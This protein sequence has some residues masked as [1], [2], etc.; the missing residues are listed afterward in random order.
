[1]PTLDQLMSLPGAFGAL[2]FSCTGDLIESRGD[3]QPDFAEVAAHLCA[4]NMANYRMQ[5][6]GWAKHTG[7]GGFFPEQGFF[8]IGLDYVIMAMG[9]KALFAR[10]RD[11]DYDLSFRVL[12]DRV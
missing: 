9:T 10:S 1:M 11:V 7:E 8:F 6:L 12:N 5:A 2:E 3:L 4:A